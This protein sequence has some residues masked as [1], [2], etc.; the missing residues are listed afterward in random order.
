M[1]LRLS[2]SIIKDDTTRPFFL[3]IMKM[4]KPH[5]VRGFMTDERGVDTLTG[6]RSTMVDEVEAWCKENNCGIRYDEYAAG[7]G[8]PAFGFDT[9]EQLAFFMLRWA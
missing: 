6:L 2:F 4:D 9:E 5:I 7:Y 3:N 1:A 8:H